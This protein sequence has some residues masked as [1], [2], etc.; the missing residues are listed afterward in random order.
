MAK[1][2]PVLHAQLTRRGWLLRRIQV[3]GALDAVFEY[4]A[5]GFG[6][7]NGTPE[8]VR[9]NGQPIYTVLR[10]GRWERHRLLLPEMRFSPVLEIEFTQLGIV[11]LRYFKL[12]LAGLVLY[13]EDRGKVLAVRQPPPLPIPAHIP[14]PSPEALPIAS[15]AS[16]VEE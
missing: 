11:Q 12:M 14:L 5:R 9:V 8:V 6:V 15:S 1:Q 10:E 7:G 3:S 4:D 13:E 16:P 2:E